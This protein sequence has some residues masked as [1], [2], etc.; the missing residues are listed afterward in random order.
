MITTR[1]TQRVNALDNLFLVRIFTDGELSGYELVFD[2]MDSKTSVTGESP[3]DIADQLE[4]V[5]H[6][7]PF[8]NREHVIKRLRATES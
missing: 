2:W 7:I 8:L 1:H 6:Y 4:S 3:Q 5:E